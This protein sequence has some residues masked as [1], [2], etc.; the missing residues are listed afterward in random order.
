VRVW[1]A[2]LGTLPLLAVG[3]GATAGNSAPAR[4]G[5]IAFQGGDGIYIVDPHT[6]TATVVLKS[7]N[8]T[9]PAWSPDGTTLA[10]TAWGAEGS[11]VSTMKPDGSERTLVLRNASSPS[12]SPDG[13]HLVVVR[14]TCGSV[15]PCSGDEQSETSLATV[16]VDGTDAHDLAIKDTYYASGP[17]WSPDGTLI[18][19]VDAGSI[20]LIT[21]DGEPV[22]VPTAP[23][24]SASVSWSPD[25][26]KL[27]YDR[28]GAKG[29]GAGAVAVVLDR[30]TG[31]ETILHGEQSGAEAP[32]WSP[33]G[34]KL[35]FNS[36]DVGGSTTTTTAS[37]GDHFA[38]HLW[39]MAPDGTKVHRVGTGYPA[40]GPASWARAAE[41][42]PVLPP[43]SATTEKTT[44]PNT[45]ATPA[46]STATPAAPAR[47]AGTA[48]ATKAK[49]PAPA[50]GA[51]AVRGEDGIYLVDPD[52]AKAHK[53]PGTAE[54]SA[55]AWSPDARLLAVEKV[56]KGGGTSIYTI[57]P[58]GT[59]PQLV[60]PNASSPSWSAEGD[61]IFAV[62]SECTTP[63]EPEDDDANVV[64]AVNLDGSNVERV[65]F[66][67]ADVYDGRELA[68]P[69]DG[70]AIHFFD[71][72]SLAGPGSF[73]SSAA[74][75]S[76]DGARLLFTGSAGPSEEAGAG[77][78]GLWIV[79]ADGG[80]PHLLLSGA[81]GRPSW[82][83]S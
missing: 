21:P 62:R 39:L 37:C 42:T 71:E 15:T 66:E 12:W 27:A 74:T 28:Y 47:T 65:D 43:A 9:D 49:P 24:E 41:S 63:C 57:W 17:E 40:Y 67:D 52:S 59:H 44:P 29:S 60:L 6:G 46:D 55:P 31:K 64:Y 79:S 3:S 35:V 2:L 8:L 25:S 68:W 19:Y 30:A 80:S 78:T 61:R 53:V 50:A 32:V 72:Q 51:I 76:P 69:T 26:S 13:K 20:E 5:L 4:N 73:D 16:N 83:S 36:M 75:W 33:E 45:T 70:S 58:N 11:N 14:D 1:L 18:A 56:E 7:E 23:V 22:A 82:V 10:V 38:S 34:D 48:T 54:M 77:K 81:S